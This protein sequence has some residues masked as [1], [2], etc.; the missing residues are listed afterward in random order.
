MSGQEVV[1]EGWL[2]KSPPEKKLRRHAWKRRWFVLRSGRLSGEPDVLQY[3]KS[4]HARRPIRTIN[5]DL[6]Q[7]VD[8]GLSF[9]QQEA[10]SSFVFDLQTAGRTWYLVC[11]SEE[12]LSRWVSSIVLL[13]GFNP[14]PGGGCGVPDTPA[15]TLTAMTSSAAIALATASA[16][17]PCGP[18]QQGQSEE[19]YLWSQSHGRTPLGPETDLDNP[20]FYV[21][22][23]SSSSSSSPCLHQSLYAAMTSDPPK[24][25]RPHCPP[26]PHPRKHSLELLLAPVQVPLGGESCTPSGYQVPRPASTSHP[27]P[28]RSPS[29]APSEGGRGW[30]P[31]P[32]PQKPLPTVQGD[33]SAWRSEGGASSRGGKSFGVHHSVSNRNRMFEFSE[34]FS[35]YFFNKGLIP[36]GGVCSDEDVDENYVPMS[37]A[38]T[39]P[40]SA[41]RD[42][43]PTTA[44]LTSPGRPVPQ[45]AHTGFRNTPVSLATP[46]TPLVRGD[47]MTTEATRPPVHRNLK[48][49]NTVTPIP[50]E[51]WQEVP[52][53][54]R[55]PVTRTFTRQP[56]SCG[57]IQVTS[58]HSSSPSSDSDDPDEGYIAMTTSNLSFSTREES[59]RL[60]LHR[61]SE[62]GARSSPLLRRSRTDK[63]VEYLDLDLHA[64]RLTSRQSRPLADEG[65]GSDEMG[66]AAEE[67]AGG[68]R[69]HVDYVVVDP[70]R[71]RA[72]RNTIEA[73]HDGRTSREGQTL[74]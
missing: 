17:P 42:P 41:P 61:A 19:D 51:D 37:A 11:D 24:Q 27:R 38:T 39:E 3:Y 53:P 65:G 71:T 67:R 43:T 15:T 28:P 46:K 62:C 36:L 48:P 60:T 34:S 21:A 40:P 6:C 35:S 31:S 25:G 72:L 1:C 4:Q 50:L 73:W 45:P 9:P 14:T 59:L 7:Q 68:G 63:Q 8:A 20:P 13:C 32:Q 18:A 2:R 57:S 12:D 52:P 49:R 26:S 22:S 74:D 55:S 16:P 10:G 56:S 44:D 33:C 54:V 29:S 70:E 5:L 47:F 23:S 30:T 66:G 64:G 69:S 58:D